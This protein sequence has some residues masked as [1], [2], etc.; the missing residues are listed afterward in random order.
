MS[1][2]RRLFLSNILMIVIPLFVSLAVFFGGLHFFALAA[3]LREREALPGEERRNW[4]TFSSFMEAADEAKELAEKWQRSSLTVISE[5]VAEFNEKHKDGRLFLTVYKDEVPITEASSDGSFTADLTLRTEEAVTFFS[6]VDA[7]TV[8]DFRVVLRSSA[9]F[10]KAPQY[11]KEIM[12]NGAIVSLIFSLFIILFTNRFLTRF[13]F[14]RI[15]HGMDTLTNG[16]HQVRDGNLNFRIDYG[17]ND[18]FSRV[19]GDFNEMAGRLLDSVEARRKDERSRKEL[20]AGISHDL[21]TPL[22]SI[23]AYVEGL[24]QGVATTQEAKNHYIDT[25]KK[26]TGDLEH[27]IDTLFLFSKLDTGEFPYDIERV[28]LTSVVFE[29]VDGLSEEYKN[30]G[31]DISTVRK[32]ELSDAGRLYADI[33]VVQMRSVMINIFENSVKYKNRARGRMNVEVCGEEETVTIVLTDDGPGVTEEALPNLFDVFYRSDES[34]SDPGN[35]SGL[36]L[37]I[38]SKIVR[39]FGGSIEAVNVPEGGLSIKMT[40]R[41][42]KE[43]KYEK[44]KSPHS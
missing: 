9:R 26:K 4:G 29:I 25:I 16:V 34:R 21:R 18:E 35:G 41:R 3:G 23:K 14:K 27:I 8:G 1:I 28:D 13:V 10:G 30:R 6:R 37:A 12:K 24:E 22:T 40:F 17:E 39:R 33:D 43:G 7:R 15:V 42:E 36:G 20:I 38:V 44:E 11:Y 19:C 2:K 5:D 31:L 32:G